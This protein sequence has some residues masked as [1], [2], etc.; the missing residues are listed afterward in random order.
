M[1]LKY[2]AIGCRDLAASQRALGVF[3]F[4][5]VQQPSPDRC[6]LA[7][8]DRGAQVVC[9]RTTGQ[10]HHHKV[11]RIA[12]STPDLRV[13]QDHL[14]KV[15]VRPSRIKEGE[16]TRYL[17]YPTTLP[18]LTHRVYEE[19][20]A[21]S[22][23]SSLDHILVCCEKGTA[24]RHARWF[25]DILALKPYHCERESGNHFSTPDLRV[26]QDHLRKVGVRPSRIKEGEETRYL[27]YPTTLPYLTH[28][29]YEEEL[30]QSPSSS[31]DHILVCCEKGTAAR[32]ARWFADILALKPYHCEDT[33]TGSIKVNVNGSGMEMFVKTSSDLP[34]F[35]F[36]E[37]ITSPNTG[38]MN[39]EGE[40]ESHLLN[41]IISLH[42]QELKCDL[43]RNK[44]RNITEYNEIDGRLNA[45]ITKHHE[46]LQ[47]IPEVYSTV[48]GNI[49]L[50][51]SKIMSCKEKIDRC[52]T[53]LQCQ[54]EDL[55]NLYLDSVKTG[56][57]LE[58]LEKIDRVREVS[59]KYDQHIKSKHYM[60]ATELLKK[61]V[62]LLDGTLAN[63]D[64][65]KDIKEE[66]KQRKE[67][68]MV[69][70]NRPNQEILVPDWL[71]TSRA[72]LITSSDWLFT[73]FGRFLMEDVYE[74]EVEDLSCD[75]EEDSYRF[76]KLLVQSLQQLGKLDTTIEYIRSNMETEMQNILVNTAQD[77]MYK[78]RQTNRME[79]DSPSLFPELL[80]EVFAKY[81]AVA[82]SHLVETLLE[83][84][85]A[86]KSED[87]GMSVNPSP[88]TFVPLTNSIGHFFKRNGRRPEKVRGSLFSF[89]SSAMGEC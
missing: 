9:L 20:L 47:Q 81:R 7:T 32:H 87:H 17:E 2:L 23:S 38:Q 14:R 25:A 65:L 44:K 49:K 89:E 35:A 43:N 86:M 58:L 75:P 85:L 26:I 6:V 22:P 83:D 39:G 42:E 53:S 19:E 57:K 61:N 1:L 73:Y 54:R 84:Y 64:A 15:G 31:L 66:L 80:A 59:G 48:L 40:R 60:H 12:F 76:L 88:V 18:Y 51:Q 27:E 45:H 50:A 70:S 13:I 4:S 67:S 79:S 82:A 30:T 33:S 37:P 69:T 16:E 56:R 3:G 11:T 71:I 55:K 72:P 24:A 41:V 8:P 34:I 46:G 78:K 77:L 10:Q 28:R 74:D 5:L 36:S 62:A 29:V 63:V 21:H 68:M 52:K